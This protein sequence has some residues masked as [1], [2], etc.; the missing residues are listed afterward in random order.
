MHVLK[1]L[2]N[3]QLFRAKLVDDKFVEKL[4]RVLKL[5]KSINSGELNLE[6]VCGVGSLNEYMDSLISILD[7]IIQH[8]EILKGNVHKV[9]ILLLILFKI[10]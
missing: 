8:R 9:N 10:V 4:S 5:S 6:Q 1:V 2:L 7:S 3:S